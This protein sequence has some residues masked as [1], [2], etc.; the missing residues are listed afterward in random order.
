MQC[1]SAAPAEAA[2]TTAAPPR[3]QVAA[4]AVTVT[5]QTRLPGI[6]F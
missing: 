4:A 2:A 6:V 5:R 3:L 1:D